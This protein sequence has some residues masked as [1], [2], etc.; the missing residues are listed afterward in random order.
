MSKRVLRPGDVDVG[1]IPP[2]EQEPALFA[3]GVGIRAYDVAASVY[4]RGFDELRA[5][6][7]ERIERAIAPNVVL[8]VSRGEVPG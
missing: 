4:P 7:L 3:G 8:L 2:T 6:Y 1:E 5:R